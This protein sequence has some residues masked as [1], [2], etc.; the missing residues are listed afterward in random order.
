MIIFSPG[1]P[2]NSPHPVTDPRGHMFGTVEENAEPPESENW[3]SCPD[4]LRGIDL[5]NHGYYWEAHEAWERLWIA[6]GRRG[7]AADFL[8]GLIKLA[9][10]GVKIRAGSRVGARRHL[11]RAAQLFRQT[12]VSLG[13]STHGC[14]GLDPQVLSDWAAEPPPDEAPPRDET[15]S[16]VFEFVL[17]PQR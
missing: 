5:F 9:A 14:F 17:A 3:L 12:I 10:A 16:P 15:A 11:S 7:V 6:A 8:K 2:G 4:Y 13:D 1:V